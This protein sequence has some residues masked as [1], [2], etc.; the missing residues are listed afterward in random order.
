MSSIQ[1]CYDGLHSLHGIKITMSNY[2]TCPINT[3]YRS[4]AQ[5]QERNERRR[6]AE[7]KAGVAST[8]P[9]EKTASTSHETRYTIKI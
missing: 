3:G 8:N 7:L 1:I 2:I 9:R 5:V 6:V 4:T